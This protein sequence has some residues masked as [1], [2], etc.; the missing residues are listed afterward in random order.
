MVEAGVKDSGDISKE[1]LR[2]ICRQGKNYA[3]IVMLVDGEP[4]GN[5]EAN[6]P[7]GRNTERISHIIIIYNK[8]N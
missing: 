8:L 3:N 2:W 6:K 5:P 1:Y 7:P 4:K